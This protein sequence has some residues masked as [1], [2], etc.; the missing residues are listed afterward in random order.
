MFKSASGMI[1]AAIE[2]WLSRKPTKTQIVVEVIFRIIGVFTFA[3]AYPLLLLIAPFREV[4]V[5]FLPAHALGHLALNFDL[6]LRRR[7]LG[8]A[9]KE[10][11]Y[12]FFIYDAANRQLLKM[13]K[14][15]VN[16]YIVENQW[17]GRLF[18][19][20]GVLNTRFCQHLVLHSNEYMEYADTVCE[21][22]FTAEEEKRGRSG[23]RE[24]G[25]GDDDWFVCIFARDSQYYKQVYGLGTNLDSRNGDIDTYIEAVKY[26]IG[27][28]GYVL[29]MGS[30]VQKPFGFTHEKVIDYALTNRSEFMDVFLTAKC[31]FFI[32]TMS[33]G[34]DTARIFDKHHLAVNVTPIGWAPWGKNELYMPKT[35]VHKGTLEQ[36]AYEQA[37]QVARP[38][39]RAHAVN[40]VDELEKL[41]MQM[42]PNTSGQILEAT[43]EM[44]ARIEGRHVDSCEYIS[45]RKLYFELLE[46]YD[47]LCKRV[48]SPMAKNYI[49]SLKL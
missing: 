3:L 1:F 48:Y 47:A 15:A 20:I 19:L 33:G 13:F 28:G 16:V 29:R 26:I 39:L 35:V 41:N 11:L 42:V 22:G 9:P 25:I 43:K 36:V 8:I 17:F 24:M 37:L 21:I 5:G 18:S 30:T 32:G 40:I 10:A 14:R 27:L 4:K 23:L 34:A 49:I 38:W 2:T 45:R 7:Q 46:K 31:R 12:I 6:F 44:I